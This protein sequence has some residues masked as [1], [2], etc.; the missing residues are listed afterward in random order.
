MHS[1]ICISTGLL[2][3]AFF[4]PHGVRLRP[5]GTVATVWYIVP[6]PHD[7]W[8]LW[9]NR[10]NVNWQGKPKYSE[11]TCPSATL[12]TTNPTL[13]GL[14]RGLPLWEV[15]C[16]K[17]AWKPMNGAKLNIT[18]LRNVY[19]LHWTSTSQLMLM[20]RW[21]WIIVLR[22]RKE[23][24]RCHFFSQSIMSPVLPYRINRASLMYYELPPLSMDLHS[25]QG[26]EQLIYLLWYSFWFYLNICIFVYLFSFLDIVGGP[27]WN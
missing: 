1:R 22:F 23:P 12:S 16:N 25:A 9:S 7:R 6:A 21:F 19:I 4:F 27:I 11:K 14:E 13:R 8:W 24:R 15:I 26:S 3:T 2:F 10:W 5:L 18:H 17:W 20:I